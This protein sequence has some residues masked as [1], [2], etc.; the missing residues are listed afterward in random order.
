MIFTPSQHRVELK[1]ERNIREKQKLLKC[2]AGFSFDLNRAF[3]VRASI[4]VQ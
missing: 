2:F 1:I 4:I 3:C